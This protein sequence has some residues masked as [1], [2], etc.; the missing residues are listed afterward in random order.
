[1]V[2]GRTAV[3]KTYFEPFVLEEYDVPE[4]EPGAV[5]LRI[6]MAGLCGSDLHTWRGDH[7]TNRPLPP[8]GMLL[9]HE[10]IGIVAMLGKGLTKDT[11]GHD[12]HEGDRVIF[13]ALAPC[14]HCQYCLAGDHNLCPTRSL[15]NGRSPAGRI[16]YFVSTY[17]DYICLP[18]FHPIFRVP[19]E[20]T[21]EEVTALNCAM[22]T[23]LEGLRVAQMRQ[24]M[25]LVTQG[26]GGLGLYAVALAKDMGASTVIAIDGQKAR[27]DLALAWGADAV[28]NINEMESPRERVEEVRRLSGGKGAD[29]VTE[30]VGTGEVVPEGIEMLAPGGAYVE[31][32][33]LVRG[34]TATIEPQALLRRKRILGSSMYR[35]EILP[36]LLDFVQRNRQ[37]VPLGRII[38]HR[39]ALSE[40]NAAFDASEWT[41]RE[42]PVIRSAIIP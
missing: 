9:G 22:G 32:G 13:S 5:V 39:F 14:N 3:L 6:T 23:V 35:P 10:G 33:N 2:R 29:I 38:S 4:P 20:I 15:V 26:A 36:T 16:P 21:D 18:A 19:D 8:T 7:G 34:R 25:S 41:D 12:L 11:A 30:L 31:I 17:S 42:T 40:I 28:I 24:G 1:M 27:L 37:T